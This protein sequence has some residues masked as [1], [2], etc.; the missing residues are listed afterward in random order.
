MK[1]C[2]A[3][4]VLAL[5][6]IAARAQEPRASEVKPPPDIDAAVRRAA[7]LLVEKQESLDGTEPASEWPYEGVYREGG[8]IPIGYRI[9]GTAIVAWALIELP[10]TMRTDATDAAVQRGIEFVL[11][12][13]DD[14]AMASGFNASYDVR[15]WGHTY[16]LQLF[17]RMRA[18][19]RVPDGKREAI[20][21]WITTLVKTL[22]A[23]E[24]V[25]T[26]G[27]NYSRGKGGAQPAPASPFMTAPT[28]LALFEARR[29]G[30]EVDAAVVA[31]ALDALEHARNEAGAIPYT[32]AGGRDEWP[33]AI[34]RSPV[35]E[36]VLLL[37]ERG[38]L[39]RVRRSLDMFLEHW[40]WLEKRRR[41][42]GTHVPPYGIAPYYFF[43]AHV[44]AAQAIEVLPEEE[45]AS[46]RG[47][48]L[49]R[50]FQVQEAS[51]GWNDRV[52]PRS[53]SFGTAM[54]VLALLAPRLP[55][56]A[57]WRPVHPK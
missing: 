50:L 30:I 34:G 16:A 4:I 38:D 47:R 29:Q 14:E 41:Q 25:E 27:W 32:T 17:L 52:F 35:T 44:Y 42:Q 24:I 12:H 23:T 1:R 54:S 26:G 10:E 45:R 11:E 49:E 19:Q 20:D 37:A 8:R 57:G 13:L 9:G 22:Q 46:Y 5:C 7:T 21:G 6:V 56:P 18:L 31:R 15:G 48:F 2:V 53:E 33:G 39:T 51:G 40:P 28:V 55:P 3:V 43:Y 36:V